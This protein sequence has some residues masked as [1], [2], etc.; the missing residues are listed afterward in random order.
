MPS[1]IN[2]IIRVLMLVGF[3]FKANSVSAHPLLSENHDR[4]I[5]IRILNNTV[6]LDYLLEVDELR[7]ARDIASLPEEQRLKIRTREQ[8]YSIFSSYMAEVL[9]INLIAKV[10]G[11]TINFVCTQKSIRINNHLQCFF[12]F[13]APFEVSP[14]PSHSFQFREGNYA[15]DDF[16]KL[17][18]LTAPTDASILTDLQLPSPEI[19]SKQPLDRGPGEAEKLRL[20]S[21]NFSLEANDKSSESNDLSI[22][23]TKDNQRSEDSMLNLLLDDK[24]NRWLLFLFALFFGAAHALTP[25]HGKTLAAAYLV[26]E[27]GT[28]AHAFLLGA[29]TTISHTGGVILIALFLPFF[30]PNAAPAQVQTIL[31]FFGG[32]TIAALGAWLLL[33][34]ILGQADHSHG[35][36]AS[37]QHNP[38]GSISVNIPD[39]GWKGIVILGIAGGIVPCWDAVAMLL[40]ALSAGLTAIALPM[41]LAFSAGMAGI[42]VAV[43]IAVVKTRDIIKKNRT[44]GKWLEKTSKLL[45]I[46]SAA[47]VIVIGV[48]L[49]SESLKSQTPH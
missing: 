47:F 27:K 33:R 1:L 17:E 14:L 24:H 12:R 10:D 40:F 15:E 5:I 28:L 35:P 46:I 13:E 3:F 36:G 34:R 23:P 21:F 6:Q 30:F 18:I 37:H 19:I 25:G 7:A 32:I 43:G 31:G 26:G 41:L 4:T 8:L 9:G 49:C 44:S 39:A 2:S 22:Q 38:D 48:W 42:L 11:K 20:A 45:P 16:S 29:V